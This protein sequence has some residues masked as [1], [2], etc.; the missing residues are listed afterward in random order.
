[1]TILT[2]PSGKPESLIIS[3]SNNAVKG[4]VSAGLRTTVFP[5]AKAG[6]IFHA[7]INN[8]KFHGVICPTTPMG[9][10]FLFGNAYSNLS[11]QPA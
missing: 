3:A 6:A 4:V 7:A 8:G 11:A 1:M 10:T 9:S 2:T 5:A